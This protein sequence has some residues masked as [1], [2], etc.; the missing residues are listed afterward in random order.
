[1]SIEDTMHYRYVNY[2]FIIPVMHI[3]VKH[4]L[5]LCASYKLYVCPHSTQPAEFFNTDWA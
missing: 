3:S 1:M 4:V 5:A 2:S